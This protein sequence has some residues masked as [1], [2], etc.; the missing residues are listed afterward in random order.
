MSVVLTTAEEVAEAATRRIRRYVNDAI[1]G[2]AV[3][4][5]GHDLTVCHF[6]CECGELSCSETVAMPLGGYDSDSAPGDVTAHH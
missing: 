4:H 5:G 1:Y 3:Q 2:A 6:M